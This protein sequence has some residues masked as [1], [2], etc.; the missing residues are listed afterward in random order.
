[1]T[2]KLP[3]IVKSPTS[4][5]RERLANKQLHVHTPNSV[6]HKQAQSKLP[7]IT[8]STSAAPPPPPV[9]PANSPV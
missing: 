3:P 2:T 8:G 1:M 5:L 4:R 7:P 9:T 6:E